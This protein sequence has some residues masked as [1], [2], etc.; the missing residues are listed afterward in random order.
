MS[1][2]PR[3]ICV[4]TVGLR[5]GR[6]KYCGDRI[7]WVTTA[8]TPGKP[9]RVLPFSWPRPYPLRHEVNDETGVGFEYW[10]TEKL[11]LVTCARREQRPRR[12]A[13]RA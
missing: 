8:S 13:G 4:A 10:P 11:H 12:S 9:S 6:C 1:Y 3:L 5:D 7:L 2:A